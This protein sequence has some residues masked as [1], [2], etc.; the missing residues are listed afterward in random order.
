MATRGL[1]IAAPGSGAGKTTVTLAL[2]RALSRAG[3]DVAGAKLGPDYID[4]GFHRAA[5]G[6]VSVNLDAWAMDPP[7]LAARAAAAPGRVLIVEAAMG[8]LDGAGRSGQGAAA[9]LAQALDLPLILVLDAARQGGS[10]ALAPAGLRALRPGLR[11]AGVIL[12]RL[13]SGRH[14]DLAAGAL[15]RAGFA[16]L[17]RLPRQ[18][19]LTLPDRHLGLIPAPELSDL[20]ALLDGAAEWLSAHAD[21][22]AILAAARPLPPAPHAPR[23]LPPPGSRI[24]V[25]QDA[26]FAFAYPHLMEDWRAQGASLH[27]FSP[28]AD[29]PPDPAADAIFLPGGY[30]E[31]HAGTLAAA[32]RFHAGMTAAAARGATIYGECG[33]YMTLGT[34]LVDATGARH[35]MLGLLPVETSFADRRLHLGYR[36][37][38]PLAGAPWT[39]PLKGHEFHYAAILD[40]SAGHQRLFRA[41]DADGTALG[42][43]GLRDGRVSGSFAHVIAPEEPR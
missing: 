6:Q 16:V 41:E 15:E 1:V 28:L 2:L 33:G 9:D 24:A 38:M 39:A 21:P 5:C 27:P 10:V 31:L 17:G 34:G 20:E 12:N 32:G 7:S 29:A 36:Y 22:D 18:P 35:A 13:G 4:P 14:A 40:E 42:E 3:R 25:A 37:L 43:I 19:D 23:R 8:A 26:A 11:I 30:P